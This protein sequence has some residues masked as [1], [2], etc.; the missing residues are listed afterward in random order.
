MSRRFPLPERVSIS[1]LTVRD[2]LQSETRVIPTEA[3]LFIIGGLLDAGFREMEVSAFAP[4]R[5][6]PQF[7]DWEA[8]VKALPDHPDATYSY[9]TTG[10]KA[11]ERALEAR[12]KGYRIDRILL[13]ILPASEKLNRT[14]VGMDYG[15]T[16]KWIRDTVQAAHRVNM[17][18]NVFLSGIFSPP[19]P[20]EGE[21]DL[22]GRALEFVEKL[23][24]LGVDDIEHPDHLGEATPDRVYAYFE[25]VFKKY[26]DPRL[27][28][29]HIHDARGMGLACYLAAM[30]VGVTRFETTFGGLG[31]WPAN[32][33]DGVPVTGVS[34]LREISR[35]P[36][37]VCT[38]DFLVM[39]DGM[40][41]QT[42][43]DLGKTLNL[44]RM[45]ERI[46]DRP[47]WSFCLGTNDR[48]GAGP[49][50]KLQSYEREGR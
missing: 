34:G 37:L 50:P 30:H 47:L 8:V 41:I 2:G 15:E 25:K 18:V 6:Q 11:T 13:G 16:W 46:V 22:M 49:V 38:E 14:V 17:K 44:G 7:R 31:G 40:G 12:Q 36:G 48:P 24:D 21:R 39:L 9:V 27:H 45:V 42:G 5:Y 20:E 32:F 35:R 1:D 26:P 23:L 28:V 19:D 3:K 33:V 43:I 10:R 4:P 29:F